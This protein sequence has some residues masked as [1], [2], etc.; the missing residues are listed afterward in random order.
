MDP[1]DLESPIS[2]ELIGRAV[3]TKRTQSQLRLVDAA[4]LCDIA[5]QTLMN[6][7][8]GHPALQTA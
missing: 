2:P 4:A 6:V 1:P 5:K 7:E 3:H 8:H